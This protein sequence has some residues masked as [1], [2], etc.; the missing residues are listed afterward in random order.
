MSAAA[1]S[2]GGVRARLFLFSAAVTLVA[3]ALLVGLALNAH[4]VARWVDDSGAGGVPL[5]LGLIILLTPALVS[6]GLLA[7]AAGYA[8]GLAAGF[9][10]A[11][12]GLTIGG[13]VAVV[14][15]R[16]V[17][18]PAAADA[19][20]PRVGRLAVWFE[21]KPL[22]NVIFSRLIPG[23]PFAITSYVCGLTAIPLSRIA[24]GSAIGFA[25]RCFVYTALGGS[26]HD[27]GSPESKLAIAATLA[28]AVA[29]LVLPRLFPSLAIGQEPKTT[30]EPRYKWTT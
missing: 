20:G 22:R 23:L 10:V 30:T 6:A 19:L 12:C 26:L 18:S 28:I 21:A 11:L 5:L 27:F 7:A 9:P 14:L 24:L 4:D 3:A 13:A 16:R 17:A 29:S 1:P 25:P 2:A 8:L 15:I